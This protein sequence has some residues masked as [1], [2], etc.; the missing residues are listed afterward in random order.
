MP[1]DKALVQKEISICPKNNKSVKTVML[2]PPGTDHGVGVSTIQVC[3]DKKKASRDE[4]LKGVKIWARKV[5]YDSGS[6]SS[7][8]DFEW[9]QRTHCKNNWQNKVECPKGTVANGLTVEVGQNGKA[10][11][12]FRGIA[13]Q[14]DK[15]SAKSSGHGH[16]HQP[17][18]HPRPGH[19]K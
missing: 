10:A 12:A 9:E 2:Q 5:D 8:D 17:G 4:R 6:V 19:R 16:G 15:P 11:N 13:L 3:T 18:H 1:K 7:S 14:C